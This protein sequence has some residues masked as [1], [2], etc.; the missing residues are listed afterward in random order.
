VGNDRRCNAIPDDIHE[1][2]THVHE[3][4]DAKDE[5]NR[6]GRKMKVAYDAI[7][8]FILRENLDEQTRL[9][10]DLLSKQ[11][12]IGKSPVRHALNSLSTEGLV[13]I[14][15][16]RGAYLR[17]FSRKEVLDLYNL[18]EALEVYAVATAELTPKFLTELRRSVQRTQKLLKSKDKQSHI[19]EDTYFHGMIAEATGNAE[20]CRVLSN[21]QSQI[22]LCRRKTYDLSASSAP[23]AHRAILYALEKGDR[24]AAQ[25]AMHRHI[26]LVR[27]RL[28]AFIDHSS[29]RNGTE[30]ALRIPRRSRR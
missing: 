18:R 30:E 9:T 25:T 3:C 7:K 13:R 10:E 8:S 1:R 24:K 4:V 14:E 16:R 23:D 28:L 17:Q 11:L 20:L 2:R 6:C 29:A 26:A 5:K 15:A 21:L 27:E 22:W 12:G 19:D